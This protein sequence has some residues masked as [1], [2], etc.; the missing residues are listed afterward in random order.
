[1]CPQLLSWRM[2]WPLTCG[3]VVGAEGGL[4]AGG[5][6]ALTSVSPFSVCEVLESQDD[7]AT[8]RPLPQTQPL[9][10]ALWTRGWR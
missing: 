4:W 9:I 7:V 5:G 1:M 3:G 2:L 10:V 8:S 6:V